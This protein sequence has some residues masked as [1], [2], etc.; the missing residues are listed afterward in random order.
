MLQQVLSWLDS[1]EKTVQAESSTWSTIQEIRVRL[2]KHKTTYQEILS[3]K[4]IIDGIISSFVS[5][6]LSDLEIIFR[7]H[8]ESE[9]GHAID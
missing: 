5:F 6:P 2:L 9:R 8:R 1:M 7:Y 4:K 3:H